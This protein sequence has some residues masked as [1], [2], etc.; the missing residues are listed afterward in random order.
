M[1]C[2]VHVIASLVPSFLTWFAVYSC[3]HHKVRHQTMDEYGN[4]SQLL[5]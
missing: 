4:R 5:A 2:L 1:K 3:A